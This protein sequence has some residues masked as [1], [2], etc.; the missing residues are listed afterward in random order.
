[1]V[2]GAGAAGAAAAAA[3][4]PAVSVALIDRV[5]EP[6]WRIGETLPGAARRVLARIGA[7]ERF[8]A[9]GHAAA[10]LKVS[11]WGSDEAVALDA[12]RDPDGVG[13][14]L[15]RAC[16]E[17]DLRTNAVV[18]GA[19][20]IAPA[21][22]DAVTRTAKGW[23]VSLAGGEVLQALQIIDAG[24]RR[25][26]LLRPFGQRR[27]VMDRLACAHQ[28]VRQRGAADPST[29]TE[30]T[31]DGWCT[32]PRCGTDGGSSPFM[33]TAISPLS[34]A[35]CAQGRSRRRSAFPALRPRSE[36]LTRWMRQRRSYAP[37]TALPGAQPGTAG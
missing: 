37:R 2:I 18:R 17:T 31:A 23:T 12:F 16:F 25:S 11:R 27:M 21:T 22:V 19:T 10:P 32:Q 24:G 6:G 28:R 36:T 20:L 30:A 4:A 34:A 1:M 14:R 29:Y 3:L 9:A 7:W 33:A 15:D 5:A 26:R 13:W 8:A 35:S